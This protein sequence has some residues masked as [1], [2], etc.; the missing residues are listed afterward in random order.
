VDGVP[1]PRGEMHKV[2]R[3]M[4]TLVY[5]TSGEAFGLP[6]LEASASGIPIVSGDIPIAR[7]LLGD[8]F[9]AVPVSDSIPMEWGEMVL[10]DIPRLGEAMLEIY[11]NQ[12]LREKLSRRGVE[13]ARRFTWDR[14]YSQFKEVLR[15]L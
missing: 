1:L 2:Y 9:L 4:D 14:S 5:A 7:E 15:K 10:V 3:V 12:D 6:F 13:I 11:S 8:N